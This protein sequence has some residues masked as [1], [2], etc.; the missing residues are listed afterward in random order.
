MSNF[1]DLEQGIEAVS[2]KLGELDDQR[3]KSNEY[4]LRLINEVEDH[5]RQSQAEMTQN[6][7]EYEQ[8]MRKYEE[9]KCLLHSLELLTLKASS[10]TYPTGISRNLDPNAMAAEVDPDHLR[11]GLQRLI[12]M[13]GNSAPKGAQAEELET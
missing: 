3:G 10:H 2:Q 12:K 13:S 4:M 11:H 5:M 1:T 6:R 9:A 8:I 7:T